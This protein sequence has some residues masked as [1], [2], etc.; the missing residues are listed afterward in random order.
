[1]NTD[2]TPATPCNFDGVDLTGKRV[3][4]I[5]SGADLNGRAMASTI[6]TPPA[7]GGVYDVVVRCN[8]MFGDPADVGHRCDVAAV[9]YPEWLIKYGLT[10]ATHFIS[11]NGSQIGGRAAG[12]YGQWGRREKENLAAELGVKNP[13]CG[14]LAVAW[15]K[16]RGCSKENLHVI[17]FGYDPK[18]GTFAGEKRYPDGT[19]DQNPNYDWARENEWLRQNVTLI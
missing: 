4:V 3:L 19:I 14:A 1:M 15:A 7:E 12:T 16:V 10:H 9:R 8:K 11:F 13:S 17:G 2:T 6:D 5:G 18:S